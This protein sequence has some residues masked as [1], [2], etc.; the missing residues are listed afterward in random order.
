MWY[1]FYFTIESEVIHMVE[2][3]LFDLLILSLITNIVLT[4]I[5]LILII[6]FTIVILKENH[7][8]AEH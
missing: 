5:S 8:S 1:H 7:I 3:I 2:S 4:I 6:A